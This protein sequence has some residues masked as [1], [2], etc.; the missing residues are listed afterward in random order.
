MM[1]KIDARHQHVVEVRHHEVGV[2]V[3]VVRRHRSRG[4]SPE[5]PPMENRN[6]NASANSIGGSN[7][8]EPFHMVAVQLNTFTP[9]GHGDQHGGQH[10]EQLRG[11]RHAD[12]EQWCAHT[13]KDRKAI[14]ATAYTIAS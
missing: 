10:E 6:R 9:V 4:M 1:P 11:E 8:S 14:E 12:R 3:L 2:L 7:D 5:K 13:M